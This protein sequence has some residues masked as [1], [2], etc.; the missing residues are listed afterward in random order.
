VGTYGSQNPASAG[1]AALP[2]RVR[3]T[4]EQEYAVADARFARV[5]PP[6]GDAFERNAEWKGSGS[7]AAGRE[8]WV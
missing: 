1:A 8:E 2:M 6:G 7:P 3:V 4:R 5:A